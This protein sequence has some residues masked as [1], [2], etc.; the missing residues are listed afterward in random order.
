MTD[1]LLSSTEAAALL[2]VSPSS[3]KRWADEGALA[4]VKTR[5]SYGTSRTFPLALRSCR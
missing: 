4:C 5:G 3:V 1:E 2:G